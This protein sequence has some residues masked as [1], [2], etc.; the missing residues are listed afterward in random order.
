MQQCLLWVIFD[1]V[2]RGRPVLRL[3]SSLKADASSRPRAAS[4]GA[5][6]GIPVLAEFYRHLSLLYRARFQANSISPPPTTVGLR[7][8]ISSALIDVITRFWSS[9]S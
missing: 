5:K 8:L 2:G 6:T 9:P 3:R 4:Q 7:Y 1:A